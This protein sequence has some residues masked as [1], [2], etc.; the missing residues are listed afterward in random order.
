M[1]A[2]TPHA[3]GWILTIRAQPKARRTEIRGLHGNALKISVSAPPED[4]KA[5][6]A[7]LHFLAKKL[8]I[9]RSRLTLL[10]GTTGRD[11][12]VLIAGLDRGEIEQRLAPD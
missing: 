8:S 2:L 5:N 7:L 1:I 4:G 11:K 3:D 10:S 12:Q 6:E 9:A